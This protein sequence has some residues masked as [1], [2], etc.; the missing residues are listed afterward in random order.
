MIYKV[1]CQK[2][3][4]KNIKF[5]KIVLKTSK[6]NKKTSIN[7]ILNKILHFKG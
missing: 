6:T 5:Q 4:E 1:F 7:K 2:S 3:Q